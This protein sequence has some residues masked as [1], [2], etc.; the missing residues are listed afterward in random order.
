MFHFHETY[1]EYQNHETRVLDYLEEILYILKDMFGIIQKVIDK[2]FSDML[3]YFIKTSK[4]LREIKKLLSV[5]KS[6]MVLVTNL[7]DVCII[8]IHLNINVDDSHIKILENVLIIIKNRVNKFK[9]LWMKKRTMKKIIQRL[10]P[11]I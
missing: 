1:K 5:I 11:P 2:E 6:I 3:K 9:V 4:V 10:S 7:S 8:V